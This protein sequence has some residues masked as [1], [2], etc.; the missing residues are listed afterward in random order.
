MRALRN[1]YEGKFRPS[2]ATSGSWPNWEYY[3]HHSSI[4][5]HLWKRNSTDVRELFISLAGFDPFA[6]SIKSYTGREVELFVRLLT[7]KI[8]FDGISLNPNVHMLER[9]VLENYII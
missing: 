8:W 5:Q 6:R 1:K 7:L 4:I 3:V 9:Q 2:L